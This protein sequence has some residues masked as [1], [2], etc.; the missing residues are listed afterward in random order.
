M[1]KLLIAIL[2]LLL[3]LVVLVFGAGLYFYFKFKPFF[4][5]VSPTNVQLEAQTAET[6]KNYATT[7][8]KNP[9]LNEQ[10]EQALEQVG[11][12]PAKL[13]TQIT[14][15]LEACFAATL[16]AD[17]VSAIK[18]GESP[19]IIDFFKAQSCINK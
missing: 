1:K 15:E 14:P 10:Q 17:R 11:V 2:I 4:I 3:L 5:D 7:T 9:L 8:D 6:E 12:D 19:T 13:P 18:S 16:G